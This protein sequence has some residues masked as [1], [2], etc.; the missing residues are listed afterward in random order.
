MNRNTRLRQQTHD[1]SGYEMIQIRVIS[2]SY[3][4]IR[5]IVGELGQSDTD[6]LRG[7]S[8]CHG[9]NFDSLHVDPTLHIVVS[10]QQMQEFADQGVSPTLLQLILT[11]EMIALDYDEA[12]QKWRDKKAK[13]DGDGPR[14]I[15]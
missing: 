11:S 5:A 14:I 8:E 1:P 9:V 3:S 4:A 6:L 10:S 7:L 12:I 15:V 2:K 13:E